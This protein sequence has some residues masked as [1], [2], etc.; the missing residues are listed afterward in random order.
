MATRHDQ[1]GVTTPVD[2]EVLRDEVSN[3]LD[4]VARKWKLTVSARLPS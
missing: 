1:G 3:A 4:S 2:L